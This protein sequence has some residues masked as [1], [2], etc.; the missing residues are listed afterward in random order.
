MTEETNCYECDTPLVSVC[1]Q[2]NPYLSAAPSPDP[3]EDEV[4]AV[5][6]AICALEHDPDGP[7]SDIYIPDDPDAIYVWAGFRPHARAAI[8]AMRP[9]LSEGE[10]HCPEH[11]SW[12]SKADQ[13]RLVR[14]L[15][16]LLN[17]EH[18]AAKQASLCDIVGQVAREK[19]SLYRG[20]HPT[21]LSEED[22]ARVEEV[23]G[24]ANTFSGRFWE[25]G[26]Q[27]RVAM[28]DRIVQDRAFLLSLIDKL[29]EAGDE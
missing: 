29:A 5:A 14:E 15:D 6:R 18:G 1:P 10:C 17:G 13:D 11:G 27:T 26:P 22:R 20:P 8:A 23:R 24:R 19:L 2:C 21:T 16:V 7:T 9:T 3:S 25:V 12:V 4:E 28:I